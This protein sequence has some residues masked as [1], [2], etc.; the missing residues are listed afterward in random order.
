MWGETWASPA[1]T[2]ATAIS[3]STSSPRI[4]VTRSMVTRFR[5]LAMVGQ[6]AL[7]GSCSRFHSQGNSSC[8]LEHRA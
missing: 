7:V 4:S 1:R 8:S 6:V 3:Q 5:V 2:A